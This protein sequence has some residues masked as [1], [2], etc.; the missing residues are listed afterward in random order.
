MLLFLTLSS[1]ELRILQLLQAVVELEMSKLIMQ[2]NVSSV[3]YLV[4][5][6]FLQ[7]E[8]EFTHLHKSCVSWH[9][10][11][12][13]NQFTWHTFDSECAL[14]THSCWMSDLVSL[15]ECIMSPHLQQWGKTTWVSSGQNGVRTLDAMSFW[16]VVLLFKI[17]DSLK[18]H[19][20]SLNKAFIDCFSACLRLCAQTS[21][22]CPSFLPYLDAT[23]VMCSWSGHYHSDI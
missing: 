9:M 15:S 23:N 21:V 6:F 4:A 16:I 18:L 20:S 17:P 13:S 2:V 3:H 5:L 14:L 8:S 10:G 1:L 19:C 7:M 22:L 11:R 12:L